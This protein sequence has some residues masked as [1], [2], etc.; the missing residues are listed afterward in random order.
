MLMS[1]LRYVHWTFKPI[2]D[3]LL[4]NRTVIITQNGWQIAE[5]RCSASTPPR[6]R[7]PFLAYPATEYP[8]TSLSGRFWMGTGNHEVCAPVSEQQFCAQ[9]HHFFCHQSIDD[10]IIKNLHDLS[11]KVFI[12]V[13]MICHKYYSQGVSIITVDIPVLNAVK[14]SSAT[15]LFW[16]LISLD[17]HSIIHTTHLICAITRNKSARNNDASMH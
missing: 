13:Y 16:L 15:M 11:L 17:M 1:C 10:I 9:K 5:Q 2:S 8:E 4:N 12:K 3:I 6:I 14:P 7:T